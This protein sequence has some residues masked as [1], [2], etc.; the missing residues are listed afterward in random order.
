MNQNILD[1]KDTK[2]EKE[3]LN[4]IKGVF[5]VGQAIYRMKRLQIYIH[6]AQAWIYQWSVIFRSYHT[7]RIDSS[8]I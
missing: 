1:R 2:Y 5:F 4:V 7:D 6:I 8:S 3:L